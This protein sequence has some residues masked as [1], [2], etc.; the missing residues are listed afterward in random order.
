[1][2]ISGH[3]HHV[4]TDEE[5]LRFLASEANCNTPIKSFE[6]LSKDLYGK[7]RNFN[8]LESNLPKPFYNGDGNVQNVLQ[9]LQENNL[10]PSPLPN[11][12]DQQL[13]YCVAA[14]VCGHFLWVNNW[15]P[16]SDMQDRNLPELLHNLTILAVGIVLGRGI[17]LRNASIT[18]CSQ[19]FG[20][21]SST[22]S[23]YSSNC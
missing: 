23:I 14:E 2:N 20:S 11:S 1:M 10:Y 19:C 22:T 9:F 18:L 7:L 15:A 5:F 12:Q 4:G 6:D 3:Y 13:S 17:S 21:R 16:A 8:M